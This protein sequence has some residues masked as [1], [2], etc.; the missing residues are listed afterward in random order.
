MMTDF[1]SDESLTEDCISHQV[2]GIIDKN[3]AASTTEID[4]GW[5]A[6]VNNPKEQKI[7]FTGIDHNKYFS[8]L[9]QSGKRCDGML[10]YKDEPKKSV[11]FIELKTGLN[12]VKWVYKAKLQ[13]LNTVKKFNECHNYSD[14]EQRQAFASNAMDYATSVPRLNDI[15][16]FFELGFEF[17]VNSVINM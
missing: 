1:F 3:P 9:F 10:Y 13:L 14:F 12:T 2:F 11:I 17:N 6:T 5:I 16:E 7:Q 8:D 4:I 15:E